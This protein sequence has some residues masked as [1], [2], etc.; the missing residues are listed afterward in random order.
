MAVNNWLNS[1]QDYNS[2]LA[3]PLDYWSL[4]WLAEYGESQ[5]QAEL[6]VGLDGRSYWTE[7]SLPMDQRRWLSSYGIEV[8]DIKWNNS[9]PLAD[10]NL[11]CVYL[12]T[13]TK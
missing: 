13:S 11:Q 9:A 5:G 10:T 7:E 4:D 12:D 8:T 6:W 3:F 2:L 1:G